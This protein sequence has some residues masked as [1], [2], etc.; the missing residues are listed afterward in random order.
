MKVSPVNSTGTPN[1][2]ANN[3]YD[4]RENGSNNIIN[5]NFVYTRS[6][7]FTKSIIKSYGKPDLIYQLQPE[8]SKPKLILIDQ[9][10]EVNN[11]IL[12]YK[13]NGLGWKKIQEL[14]GQ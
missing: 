2:W 14:I 8:I 13:K 11:N 10:N 6:Y 5:Y 12:I 1:L 3:I 4:Y 9:L 7:D